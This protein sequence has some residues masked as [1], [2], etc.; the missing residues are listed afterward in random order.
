MFL[1]SIDGHDVTTSQSKSMY[2]TAETSV[3]S[4][5]TKLSNSSSTAKSVNE[6]RVDFFEIYTSISISGLLSKE[7]HIAA[8][9]NLELSRTVMQLQ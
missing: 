3:E 1:T 2:S 7:R 9:A 6:H 4:Y 5:L 8:L